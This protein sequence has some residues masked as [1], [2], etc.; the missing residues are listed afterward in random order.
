M[1]YVVLQQVE[2]CK[3]VDWDLKARAWLTTIS[4]AA[5]RSA[6][7][8][9]LG[10]VWSPFKANF[11]NAFGDKCWYSE[12]PRINAD[13]DVDHFRPKGAIKKA[14]GSFAA[15][16]VNGVV[17]KHPG[18]WWLAFEPKNYRYACK[19]ANQPRDKGGKHDYFPLAS[20]ATRIW[21]QSTLPAHTTEL[22][23]LLDPC[24]LSDVELLSFDK[25][26]GLAHSRFD[27]A[28]FPDMYARVQVSTKCYNLNNKSVIGHRLKVINDVSDDLK[29]LEAIWGLPPAAK[30]MM[31]VQFDAAELR[32]IKACDRKSPFSAAAV[33]FV[34]PKIAEPWIVNVLP[35]LDLTP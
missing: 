5:D 31:Q 15:R 32:L 34:K 22:V 28:T 9:K 21:N 7:F 8:K 35:R 29:L 6:T 19:Y 4:Q 12:V 14:K 2:A 26:P 17:E 20:E 23:Q 18:Y 16:V 25:S 10:S 11:I 33:A 30:Q 3:P 1:R 13:F 27:Q 24:N